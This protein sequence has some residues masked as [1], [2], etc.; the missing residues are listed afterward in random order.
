MATRNYNELKYT[1]LEKR[2]IPCDV[3]T[4]SSLIYISALLAITSPVWISVIIYELV[5]NEVKRLM[6]KRL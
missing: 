5:L 1:N 3:P 6:K 4:I 2:M